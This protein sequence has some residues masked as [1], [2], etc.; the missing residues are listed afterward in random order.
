MKHSLHTLTRIDDC[1]ELLAFAIDRKK[2]LEYKKY[3]DELKLLR[4]RETAARVQSDLIE[5]T[6]TIAKTQDLVAHL[7]DS[8]TDSMNYQL[9]SLNHRKHGIENR[10]AKASPAMILELEIAIALMD[11]EI[12]E[13]ETLI[14]NIEKMRE[15]LLAA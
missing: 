4:M 11:R 1:D 2:I 9:L 8:V 7:P 14:K 10:R 13:F 15:S 5:V 3:G 6:D 12:T